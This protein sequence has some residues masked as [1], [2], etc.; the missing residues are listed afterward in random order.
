MSNLE[1]KIDEAK[2]LSIQIVK[3]TEDDRLDDLECWAS[4]SWVWTF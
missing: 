3:D 2:E 1:E 4:A